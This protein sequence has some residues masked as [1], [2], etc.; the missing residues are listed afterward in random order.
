[1]FMWFQSL[2]G[3]VAAYCVACRASARIT[4]VVDEDIETPGGRRRIRRGTC[5]TCGAATSQFVASS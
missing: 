3:L 5:K 2:L 1:M 4:G